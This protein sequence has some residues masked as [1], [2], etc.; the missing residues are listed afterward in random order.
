M[1][2]EP[3]Q[4]RAGQPLRAEDLAPLVE[5]EVGGDQDGAPLAALAEGLEEQFRPGG[6]QG[7][8][9]NSSMISRPRWN[10]FRCRLNSRLSSQTSSGPLYSFSPTRR[11]SAVPP[12]VYFANM[13][14][15]DRRA[16]RMVA[17]SGETARAGGPGW[18]Q[19]GLRPRLETLPFVAEGGGWKTRFIS[20][21]QDGILLPIPA[22]GRL[23]HAVIDDNHPAGVF[24]LFHKRGVWNAPRNTGISLLWPDLARTSGSTPSLI[25]ARRFMPSAHTGRR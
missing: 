24:R 25:W 5:G 12:P 16:C 8:E 7:D 6:G 9:A 22:R 20:T 19:P 2:G 3:V 10:S 14:L 4:Q 11:P 17:E 15:L 23:V 21:R 13:A 1:V 18:K